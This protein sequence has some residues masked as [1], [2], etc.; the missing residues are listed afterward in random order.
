VE[1]DRL[2]DPIFNITNYYLRKRQLSSSSSTE[3]DDHRRL[4]AYCKDNCAGKVAGTCRATGCIGYRRNL[5]KED[6]QESDQDARNTQ[7]VV[8]S[9]DTQKINVNAALDKLIS[10]NAVTP[11]C[12]TF[13]S[14]SKRK[15][16]CYDD[17]I[18]GEIT[19]FTFWNTNIFN[20]KF[21]GSQK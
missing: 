6:G 21:A 16:E 3:H 2:I 17:I 10:T 15:A 8:V 9:C 7:A 14:L 19:S 18:Y 12:K 11:S 1:D 5:M 4:N 13:L 20:T